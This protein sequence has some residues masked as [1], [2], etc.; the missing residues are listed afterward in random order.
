[1]SYATEEQAAFIYEFLHELGY[2]PPKES[3]LYMDG[4]EA[5]DLVE[6]IKKLNEHDALLLVRRRR[7]GRVYA[8]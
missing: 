8:L 2:D 4:Q 6:E 3:I 7:H 1:M 5:T